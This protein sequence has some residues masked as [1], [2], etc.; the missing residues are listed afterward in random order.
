MSVIQTRWQELKSSPLRALSDWQLM[1]WWWCVSA[2]V[3]LTMN[4]IAHYFFQGFMQMDPCEICIYT[5]YAM[6][7]IVLG[8]LIAALNP[9]LLLLRLIGYAMTLY[10]AVFGAIW[11]KQLIDNYRLA[12][13]LQ[14]GVDPFA[15]GLGIMS[16]SYEPTFHFGLPWDKWFPGWFSP[17]GICGADEWTFLG[18]NMGG[19]TL[20]IFSVY[21]ILVVLSI[22][23]SLISALGNKNN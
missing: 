8:G 7:C 15:A 20:I 2:L 18:L 17:T 12:S 22:A 21:I 11:S 9:K 14:N 3:A 16:C 4:L 6:F 1:R 5:R 13:D 23:A 19:W 10:G